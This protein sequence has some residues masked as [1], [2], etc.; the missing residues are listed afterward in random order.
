MWPRSYPDD[1]DGARFTA[2]VW[3]HGREGGPE[4]LESF[5]E[6]NAVFMPGT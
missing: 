1:S 2:F 3:G 5:L 6:T 4:G